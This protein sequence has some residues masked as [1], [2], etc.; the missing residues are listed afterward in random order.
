MVL[1]ANKMD[2]FCVLLVIHIASLVNDPFNF[3][4]SRFHK[5]C[6]CVL[7][8]VCISFCFKSPLIAQNVQNEDR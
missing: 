1:V 8:N 6:L 5:D 3:S 2:C 4:D 7:S